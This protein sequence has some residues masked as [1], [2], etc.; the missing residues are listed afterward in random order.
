MKVQSITLAVMLA[1]GFMVSSATTASAED[2]K[3]DLKPTTT[4][5]ALLTDSIGKRMALRLESGEEIEGTVSV[6][7][8]H[9]VLVSK[10]SKRDFFDA[11]VNIDRISAVIIRAR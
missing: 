10:L 1:V 6:V 2:V 9:L 4:M 5:K 8:D 7:G 3:Y 11:F